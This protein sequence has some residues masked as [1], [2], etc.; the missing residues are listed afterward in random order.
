[1]THQGR[2]VI[3]TIALRGLHPEHIEQRVRDR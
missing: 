3:G 2:L 1:M